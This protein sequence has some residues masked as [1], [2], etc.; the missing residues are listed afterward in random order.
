[1]HMVRSPLHPLIRC[2]E[3]NDSLLT[4][5]VAGHVCFSFRSVMR[6]PPELHPCIPD[7]N[8]QKEFLVLMYSGRPR[9]MVLARLR[10]L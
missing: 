9:E 5:T 3:G 6:T 4:T 7:I 2:T 8:V 1:M 10:R